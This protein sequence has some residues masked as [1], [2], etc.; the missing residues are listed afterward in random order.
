MIKLTLI[1]GCIRGCL[2]IAILTFYSCSPQVIN[3]TLNISYSNGNGVVDIDGNSYSSVIYGNGQEWISEN[4]RATHF[5]NGDQILD[6]PDPS[7]WGSLQLTQVAQS[8]Y[9]GDNQYDVPYGRFYNWPAVTDNRNVCPTGWRTPTLNDWENLL[10]YFGGSELSGHAMRMTGTSFWSPPNDEATNASGFSAVGAGERDNITGGFFIIPSFASWWTT[11]DSCGTG[12]PFSSGNCGFAVLLGQQDEVIA[13]ES[14]WGTGK[15]VRCIKGQGPLPI[16]G[17]HQFNVST[18]S[19]SAE[20]VD[21]G[22]APIVDAGICWNTSS[23]PTFND[24]TQHNGPG[25]VI[26]FGDIFPEPTSGLTYFVRAFAT[27]TF[28]TAYGVEESFIAP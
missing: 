13:D 17:N 6:V 2:C 24:Q 4:L 23:N 25:S 21:N 20:I 5:A 28:G 1:S 3:P 7:G 14:D 26:A 22:G 15:T 12:S 11:L 18:L 8:S 27:N 10:D 19:L 16:L 9:N